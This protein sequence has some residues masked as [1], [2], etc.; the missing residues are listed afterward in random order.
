MKAREP[1]VNETSEVT[2]LVLLNLIR[3]LAAELVAGEHRDD[4]AKL[5]GAMDRQLAATPLP[6]GIDVNDARAGIAHARKLLQPYMVRVRDLALA[7]RAR[8]E[9]EAASIGDRIQS[10]RPPKYFQ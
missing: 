10:L 7:V 3:L 1:E 9:A 2:T 6:R 4:V 5:I 8:D